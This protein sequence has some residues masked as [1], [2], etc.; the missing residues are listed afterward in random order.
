M[1]NHGK[2]AIGTSMSLVRVRNGKVVEK[3][4]PRRCDCK[5]CMHA[6]VNGGCVNCFITGEIAVNKTHCYYY[7]TAEEQ[8]NRKTQGRKQKWKKSNCK[9]SNKRKG[10]GKYA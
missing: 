10:G 3:K 4:P 1:S 6:V 7:R 9:S 2:G 5:K 8:A